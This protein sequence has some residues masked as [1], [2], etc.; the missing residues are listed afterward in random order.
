M[1][2]SAMEHH[3]QQSQHA[4][5]F[6]YPISPTIAFPSTWPMLDPDKEVYDASAAGSTAVVYN[7]YRFI[8]RIA[9]FQ[10]YYVAVVCTRFTCSLFTYIL[11]LQ[12]SPARNST[13][14]SRE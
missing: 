1:V 3:L 14:R 13:V 5:I 7:I 8:V 11:Y 2:P 4:D 6:I 10:R 9:V 12:V